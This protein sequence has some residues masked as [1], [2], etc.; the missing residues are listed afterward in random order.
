MIQL[1]F[2][3]SDHVVK[4]DFTSS[5]PQ[6]LVVDDDPTIR[7]LLRPHLENVGF[8]VLTA[9]S[10]DEAL[11]QIA[12]EGL[13]HLAIVDINMPG[14]NG[15][16]LCQ[17]IHRFSDLPIIMLTAVDD[18]NTV[19]E[20][21]QQF[22]ED[23]VTKPFRPAELAARAIRVHS[24]RGDESYGAGRELRIDEDLSVDFTRCLAR[25]D[26]EE[27]HLTAT[28]TKILYI[29]VRRAGRPVTTSYLLGRLWPQ[30]DVFED[31]LR[32]HVHRLR[33]K[34]EPDSSEP[35]YLRTERGVGYSFVDSPE[36]TYAGGPRAAAPEPDRAPDPSLRPESPLLRESPPDRILRG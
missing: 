15:I 28:E 10:T 34:L 7:S 4:T 35:I 31:T 21:I 11:D 18:E 8:E 20:T 6:L 32:V 19:V 17:E 1:D 36:A 16:E 26:G 27:V 23:Y 12:R 9:G 3:A 2:F 33:Q 29:L 30:G 24:R 22:A 5:A 25:R 13:P 14:R